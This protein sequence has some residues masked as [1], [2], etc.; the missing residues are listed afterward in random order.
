MRSIFSCWTYDTVLVGAAEKLRFVDNL[1]KEYS[2]LNSVASLAIQRKQFMY[3]YAC[4]FRACQSSTSC[5]QENTLL[6]DQL[7]DM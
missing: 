5:S 2:V 4:E 1:D 6:H 7:L 3:S